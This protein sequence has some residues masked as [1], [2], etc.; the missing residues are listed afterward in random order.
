MP[1]K[2]IFIPLLHEGVNVLR[3]T[4]GEELSEDIFKVLPI[5]KYDS[6]DEDWEYPPGSIVKCEKQIKNGKVL[7]VAIR[8]L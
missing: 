1:I 7:L 8:K 4:F 3:P 5:D 2:E 6:E